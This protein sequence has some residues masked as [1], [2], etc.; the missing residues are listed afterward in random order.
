MTLR[1]LFE[2]NHLLALDKPAGMPSVPDDSGD[3][4]LLDEAK[5]WLK[6]KYA[7]PGAV[8]LGVVHR[9]DRPVSGVQLFA[10]TSKAAS[11]LSESWRSGAARKE[12]LGWSEARS[13]RAEAEGGGE[14]EQW[15][16]KDEARNVVRVVR[17]DAADAK[18]ATTR[19]SR[20]PGARISCAWPARRSTCRSPAT[21]STAPRGRCRTPGSACTRRG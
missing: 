19:W 14:L 18:R 5:A 9:L 4:S 10:R 8:F 6:E 7:K 17:P 3:P 13:P 16:L 21:S 1:V 2:D 20:R 15:L 12:Y 11:R